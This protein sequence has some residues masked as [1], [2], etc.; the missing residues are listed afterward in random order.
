MARDFLR[1]QRSMHCSVVSRPSPRLYL[2][3]Y[4][5]TL[6]IKV[7]HLHG[8]YPVM[9]VSEPH[10]FG[11]RVFSAFPGSKFFS[12]FQADF[13]SKNSAGDPAQARSRVVPKENPISLTV[14]FFFFFFF[15]NQCFKFVGRP[16]R[17]E[18]LRYRAFP[19][20]GAA[21][22][23]LCLCHHIQAFHN[24]E[25]QLILAATRLGEGFPSL[26]I[27]K[28]S[29]TPSDRRWRPRQG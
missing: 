22:G 14:F 18:K 28:L 17:E 20:V 10:T 16:H 2:D 11:K 26:S 4:E 15:F 12:Y 3:S 29:N 8:I 13:H 1:D 21:R 25:S 5:K 7:A 9:G 23:R 19:A 27:A 6:E 24:T